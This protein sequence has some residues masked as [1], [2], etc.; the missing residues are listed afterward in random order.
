[1]RQYPDLADNP[2]LRAKLLEVSRTQQTL[3]KWVAEAKPAAPVDLPAAGATAITLARR[4]AKSDVP[5]VAGQSVLAA[6]NG[7]VYGLDAAT[8]KVLW[9]RFIGFD[10]NPQAASMPVLPLSTEPG[11]DALVVDTARNQ[12][13]R[14]DGAA[15]KVRWRAAI[16]EPFDARAVV[17]DEKI[18]LA[19]PGGKL[20]TIAAATGD[21]PGYVQLPQPLSVAPAVDGRRSLIYQVAARAN[22][23]ILGLADGACRHVDYL[24]HELGSVVTAPL[25]IDDFLLLV[26]NDGARD[27]QL[28]VYLVQPKD[29]GK[30]EPWLKLVQ[31]VPLGGVVATPLLADRR[32]ILATTTSGKVH[33][34]VLG[35]SE[36]K[37][38]LLQIAESVIEVADNLIR[39]PLLQGGQLFIADNRLTKYDVQTARGRLEPKWTDD[40]QSAFLQPPLAVGQAVVGVRRKL[41]NPG[42]VV[43]ARAMPESELYWKTRARR[44]AG[45]RTPASRRRPGRRRH[46]RRGRVQDRRRP[47]GFGRPDRAAG[48][49][50][51]LPASA[52]G[53]TRG[54][55]FRRAAGH[56]QRQGEPADRHLRPE[57]FPA[58][59]HLAETRQ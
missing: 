37:T 12:L 22:L 53:E 8:G 11:G 59:G 19:T 5:D 2:K 30:P 45:R 51:R 21:S 4:E 29:P 17:A 44:A 32:R 43:T 49:A 33:V 23:F 9:R 57:E 20:L 48:P 13:L 41:G 40:E 16:G 54:P 50:R 56:Q 36:A 27:A 18:L 7:A 55:A 25:A 34:F 24:G 52:A 31:Q 28:R 15:G 6:V 35:G 38:P 39:F 10:A 47:G 14:L 46:R 3:V 42:A 58:A 1:M 26:V